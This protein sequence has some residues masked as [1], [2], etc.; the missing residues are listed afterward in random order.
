MTL[1]VSGIIFLFAF[2]L[3]CAHFFRATILKETNDLR[4]Y[5]AVCYLIPIYHIPIIALSGDPLLVR[6]DRP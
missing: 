2:S 4:G 1:T 5:T 3:V 6:L